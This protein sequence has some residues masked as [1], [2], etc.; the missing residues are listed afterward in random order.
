MARTALSQKQ[1]EAGLRDLTGWTLEAGAGAIT[2]R[3]VFADF[4]EA[5]GFMARAALQAEK[6]D[7][8]PEWTNVYKKVEVRLTTHD[9]GGVTELDLAL[10]R[11]MD[12]I[13][14]AR[15]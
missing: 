2:R 15:S 6:L 10:A 9:A 5:F 13:A 4:S 12:A 3:F 14:G 11:A 8:H 7:H 1:A